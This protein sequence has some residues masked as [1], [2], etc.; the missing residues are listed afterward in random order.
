MEDTK[1][2]QKEGGFICHGEISPGEVV[3]VGGWDRDCGYGVEGRTWAVL[4]ILTGSS[5][6][7]VHQQGACV[8]YR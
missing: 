1:D 5:V 8:F 3:L 4:V 6:Q 2:E 7:P